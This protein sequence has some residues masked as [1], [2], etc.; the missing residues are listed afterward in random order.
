VA[1][2]QVAAPVPQAKQVPDDKKNPVKQVVETGLL[3]AEVPVETAK[4]VTPDK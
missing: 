2:E 3:V 1:D 4:Q